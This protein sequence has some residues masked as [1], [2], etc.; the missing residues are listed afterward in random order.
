MN[1]N[2]RGKQ[3]DC[4]FR[5]SEIELKM[6]MIGIGVFQIALESNVIGDGEI[7]G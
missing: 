3:A 1:A 7:G 6:L 5:S 2:D 4:I